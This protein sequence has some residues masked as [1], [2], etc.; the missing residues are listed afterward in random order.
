MFLFINHYNVNSK[1]L[2]HLFDI[3]I[4]QTLHSIFV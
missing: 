4:K 3:F 2:Q 1:L